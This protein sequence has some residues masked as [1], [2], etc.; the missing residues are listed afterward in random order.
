MLMRLRT[1]SATS[2][3]SCLRASAIES[4]STD[5]SYLPIRAYTVAIS[6]SEEAV[7]SFEPIS[8]LISQTPFEIGQGLVE[9]PV[10]LVDLPD[11]V[12]G[13]GDAHLVADF[14]LD[15][16]GAVEHLQGLVALAH[17]LVDQSQVAQ[18]RGNATLVARGP[19]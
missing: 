3:I 13:G 6:E 4:S 1:W 14:P 8:R 2:P 7:R 5:L 12:E 15:L 10:G 16:K 11:L 18:A 9:P 17:D 19:P